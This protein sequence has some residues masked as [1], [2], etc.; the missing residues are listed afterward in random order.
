MKDLEEHKSQNQFDL[1]DRLTSIAADR[2]TER[3]ENA[4]LSNAIQSAK[5]RHFESFEDYRKYFN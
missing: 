2:S 1:L 5:D 3:R 4:V